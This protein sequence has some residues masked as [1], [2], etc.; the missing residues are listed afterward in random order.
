[1]L[2]S[3]VTVSGYAQVNI[4][5]GQEYYIQSACGGKYLDVQWGKNSDGT[6]LWLWK[7]NGGKAQKYTLESAGNGYFYLKIMGKYVSIKGGSNRTKVPIV[8]TSKKGDN[9]KWKFSKD[10]NGYYH[11][12]SK[13]GTY[14]DVEW[15]N[16]ADKTLIWTWTYNTTKAQLWKLIPIMN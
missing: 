4:E 5:S 16:S 2:L 3:I 11:I 6:P 13:L 14:M 10:S 15:A 1:M 8:L 12:Q 9:T 7:Y